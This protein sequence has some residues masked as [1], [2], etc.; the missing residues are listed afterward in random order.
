MKNRHMQ[1]IRNPYHHKIIA[2]FIKFDE[3]F[4][5]KHTYLHS[6]T[7][8]IL[9]M[10]AIGRER[11]CWLYI[12]GDYTWTAAEDPIAVKPRLLDSHEASSDKPGWDIV[13]GAVYNGNPM[14]VINS[15][16]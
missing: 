16:T 4:F 14:L 10:Y 1:T 12:K 3:S 7:L 9:A 2:S 8:S 6:T 15:R 13:R 11:H 5:K